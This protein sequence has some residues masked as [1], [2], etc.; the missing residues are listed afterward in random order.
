MK[1]ILRNI[2][3][4]LLILLFVSRLTG[5]LISFSVPSSSSEP[6]L[7]VN[8]HFIGTNLIKPKALD[9]AYFKF[10]DSSIF[11][12]NTIV[13]RLI[14]LPG[15][16]LECKNGEYFVNDANVDFGLD[17]RFSYKLHKNFYQQYIINNIEKEDLESFMIHKDS[18]LVYLDKSFVNKLPVK[19]DRFSNS[20][21][22]NLT[23][24]I[25]S[26][27][28]SWDQ[29][30]FGPIKLP[31]NKYFF[32]GDSRDNSIDSRFRGF[33]DEGKIKGTLL[34]KF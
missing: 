7:K 12:N 34:F 32:S 18:F 24:D 30:N 1:K 3:I 5:V 29:N 13:K 23:S 19:I 14:A 8:S 9:F 16:I 17:L 27:N 21:R 15:D 26:R 31:D 11:G 25:F 33:V 6:N 2:L 4:G 22:D 10:S 20:N 28:S